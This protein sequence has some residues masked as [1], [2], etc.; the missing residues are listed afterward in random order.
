MLAELTIFPTDKGVSVSF[1]VAKVI[2][3][4]KNESEKRDLKYELN[5][6]GTIIEGEFDDVWG[7]LKGCHEVMRKYSNRIYIVINIDDKKGR[8]N[9]IE[10][11]VRSIEDKIKD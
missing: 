11:K 2:E 7:V 4:I 10:E 6:M 8:E 5:A 1:Y 9:A 3:Y